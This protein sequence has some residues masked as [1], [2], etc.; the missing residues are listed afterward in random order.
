[1]IIESSRRDIPAWKERVMEGDLDPNRKFLL[2]RRWAHFEFV[3]NGRRTG[4]V[5][6]RRVVTVAQEG[7]VI[8]TKG[9]LR[10]INY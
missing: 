9:S 1:M 4:V 2:I 7:D 3:L 8:I 5:I 10:L 6:M